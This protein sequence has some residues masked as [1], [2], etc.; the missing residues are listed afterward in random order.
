MSAAYDNKPE[1]QPIFD[2]RRAVYQ[3][4]GYC[5]SRP[6]MLWYPR[7]RAWH[8]HLLTGTPFHC[9]ASWNKNSIQVR[10]DHAPE[11]Y[12]GELLSDPRNVCKGIFSWVL[13]TGGP[14]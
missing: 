8:I 12:F 1:I 6:L 4:G 14:L 10:G 9:A 13:W 2:G 3:I 7:S 5:L 11:Y